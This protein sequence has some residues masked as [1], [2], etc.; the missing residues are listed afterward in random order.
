[1]DHEEIHKYLNEHTPDCMEFSYPDERGYYCAT[2]NGH[3]S[4]ILIP[5]EITVKELDDFIDSCIT[6]DPPVD[7]INIVT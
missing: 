1:M 2:Y 4:W 7:G 6:I 5:E 3:D